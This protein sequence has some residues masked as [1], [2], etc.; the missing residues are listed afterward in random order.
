MESIKDVR[1]Q[2]SF[3][4][5]LSEAGKVFTWGSGLNGR[6]GHNNIQIQNCPK[7]VKFDF[8]DENKKIK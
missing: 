5:A 1:I 4:L 7:E 8:K 2:E 3:T 6:L